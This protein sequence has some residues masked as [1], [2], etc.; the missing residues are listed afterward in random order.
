[1]LRLTGADGQHATVVDSGAPAN[2]SNIR[3]LAS[4]RAKPA[5]SAPS[6][7]VEAAAAAV[8][9]LDALDADSFPTL[10]EAQHQPPRA[11]GR[12]TDL[13]RQVAD[14]DELQRR[15][16][17]TLAT[18]SAALARKV[19]SMAALLVPA[20]RAGALEMDPD[21]RLQGVT[22]SRASCEPAVSGPEDEELDPPA[23]REASAD[24]SAK[25]DERAA[26]SAHAQSE[27]TDRYFDLLEDESS[28]SVFQLHRLAQD[29]R[30]ACPDVL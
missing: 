3:P 6:R 19:G 18:S 1:M 13:Q 14:A 15:I 5:P 22:G 8:V 26:Q 11:S 10:Q 29:L 27:L 17:R 20:E 4:R 23:A 9:A 24:E 25:A 2:A 30:N 28:A 21:L 7:P 16:T 12:Y